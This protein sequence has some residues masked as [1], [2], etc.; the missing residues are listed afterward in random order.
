LSECEHV[1]GVPHGQARRWF[2]D[3]SPDQECRYVHGRI[4]GIRSCYPPRSRDLRYKGGWWISAPIAV[5]REIMYEAG[6]YVG[7][8]ILDADGPE[9]GQA[10][11][12]VPPRPTGVPATAEYGGDSWIYARRQGEDAIRWLECRKWTVQGRLLVSFADGYERSYHPDGAI[13]CEGAIS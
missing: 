7:S 9:I 13:R 12:P 2:A 1:A 4:E 10:G 5:V 11:Q 6:D 3:G 8:R